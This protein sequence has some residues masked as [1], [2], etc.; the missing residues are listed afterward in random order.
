ML[1]HV[2]TKMGRN[3]QSK[4]WII[5]SDLTLPARPF[6][7]KKDRNES[8]IR[9]L[10]FSDVGLRWNVGYANRWDGVRF[11]CSPLTL[12]IELHEVLELVAGFAGVAVY[13]HI[14]TAVLGRRLDENVAVRCCVEHRRW[15]GAKKGQAIIDRLKRRT[16]FVQDK[17]VN[18]LISNI[19]YK[20]R[21]GFDVV[22]LRI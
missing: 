12:S 18:K 14:R 19:L 8:S 3:F 10:V 4:F 13:S 7:S 5:Y 2:I 6:C 20:F 1:S 22:K 11:E 9:G 15:G 17:I 16:G 21:T